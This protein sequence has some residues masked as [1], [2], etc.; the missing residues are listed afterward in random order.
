MLNRV[1]LLY[2]TLSKFAH[3]FKCVNSFQGVNSLIPWDGSREENNSSNAH[4]MYNMD[5]TELRMRKRIGM[6]CEGEKRK[7]KEENF[8]NIAFLLFPHLF[9]SFLPSS[10]HLNPT[11]LN[12]T[13]LPSFTFFQN[14]NFCQNP[15]WKDYHF[16]GKAFL[17]CLFPFLFLSK[18]FRRPSVRPSFL[19][20][21]SPF[22]SSLETNSHYFFSFTSFSI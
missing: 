7:K 8:I 18:F 14:A 6:R 1:H 15:D 12:S 2:L 5:R 22:T 17:S 16:G 13:H 19:S 9:P 4:G 3:S 21:F 10:S 20:S 11:Q